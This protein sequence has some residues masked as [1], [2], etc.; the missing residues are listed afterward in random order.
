MFIIMPGT[1]ITSLGP[2][3]VLFNENSFP[4]LPAEAV[5]SY[6]EWA[7]KNVRHFFFSYNHEDLTHDGRG[8]VTT[9]PEM[10]ARVGGFRRLNRNL[11]WLRPCYV[12]ELWVVG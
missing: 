2:V 7:R 1:S 12:E 5:T 8:A 11:S 10:M 3:D 4:E 9:V 6:L